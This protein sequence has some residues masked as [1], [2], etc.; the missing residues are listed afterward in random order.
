MKKGLFRW[1]GT[2]A[3][4]AGQLGNYSSRAAVF[5]WTTQWQPVMISNGAQY[6]HDLV[7]DV[8]TKTAD[9]VGSQSGPPCAYWDLYDNHLQFRLVVSATSKNPQ[10]VWQVFFDTGGSP[11]TLEYVLQLDLKMENRVEFARVTGGPTLGSVSVGTLDTD[12][13]WTGTPANYAN[14]FPGTTPYVDFAI[15]YSTF[16]TLT[17]TT[18]VR[19]LFTTS[20]NHNNINMDYP[21]NLTSS[22]LIN[23]ALSDPVVVPEP[24]S[25]MLATGLL[26]LAALITKRLSQKHKKV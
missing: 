8:G 20:A 25:G 16:V 21:L 7:N 6:Y 9:L 24:N 19:L 23:A 22:D 13:L 12:I 17:G 3:I 18:S 14:V 26:A 1:L 11:N 4:V 2:A 15:P 5:N 10:A